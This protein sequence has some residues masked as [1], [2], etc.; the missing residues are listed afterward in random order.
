MLDLIAILLVF[1]R[2]WIASCPHMFIAL[3]WLNSRPPQGDEHVRTARNPRP[4]LK[5]SSQAVMISQYSHTT[6]RSQ[7]HSFK[8]TA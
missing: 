7:I 2:P 3:L 6:Q 8:A 4:L 1:V 5:L